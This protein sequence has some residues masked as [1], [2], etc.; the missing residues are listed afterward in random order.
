MLTLCNE[1]KSTPGKCSGGRTLQ[2][3]RTHIEV[4]QDYIY[5]WI[6]RQTSR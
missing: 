3:E 2:D 4:K 5:G 6:G 1:D